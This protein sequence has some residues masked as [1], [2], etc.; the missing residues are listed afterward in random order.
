MRLGDVP[1]HIRA[2]LPTSWHRETGPDVGSATQSDGAVKQRHVW[3]CDELRDEKVIVI[4]GGELD[5]EPG[6]L[7]VADDG[8]V[9][10]GLFGEGDVAHQLLGPACSH[11]MV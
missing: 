11:I 5:P 4:R 1:R 9:E 10:A 3:P 8:E 6:R 7:V 2:V